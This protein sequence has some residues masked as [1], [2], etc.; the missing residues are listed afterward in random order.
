M[1]VTIGTTRLV[2]TLILLM[3]V[4]ACNKNAPKLPAAVAV[5]LTPTPPARLLI[6]VELPEPAPPEPA[7]PVEPEPAPAPVRRDPVAAAKPTEKP[8]TTPPAET[9]PAPVL[10]TTV[11]TAAQE[12]RIQ[13][14]LGAAQQSL[15]QVSYRELNPNAR[16]QY[17]QA[18]TFI[19]RANDALK[20]KNYMFAETLA[21]R[22][23]S[24]AALL[25]K[26]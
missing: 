11:N 24:L 12:R 18:N 15:G 21:T 19:R 5:M 10:T 26:G 2:T 7:V 16:A 4:A 20:V 6:P 13:Q 17:D 9:G 22:A 23:A 14:L 1:G 3:S 25:V 8:A